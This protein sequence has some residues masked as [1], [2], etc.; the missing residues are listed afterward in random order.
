MRQ[1]VSPSQRET[2]QFTAWHLVRKGH[3]NDEQIEEEIAALAEENEGLKNIGPLITHVVEQCSA[4]HAEQ[5]ETWNTPTDCDKLDQ[6]AKVLAAQGI[7]FR[8]MHDCCSHCALDE[9]V[10]RI[11]VSTDGG[12]VEGYAFCHGDDVDDALAENALHVSFG[13]QA[14]GFDEDGAVGAL[15]VAELRK[16]GL[17]P[18]WSGCPDTRIQ[19]VNFVWRKR[20]EG[21]TEPHSVKV[22]DYYT[23][24]QN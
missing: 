24:R 8:V 13:S 21:L 15:V 7:A 20:R 18:E 22:N 17:E 12:E 10:E 16:A 3:L 14:G 6:V 1:Q 23:K 11:T 9:L 2:I 5:Q 4:R 19:L